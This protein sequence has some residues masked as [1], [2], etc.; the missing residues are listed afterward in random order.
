MN[1]YEAGE[2]MSVGT[3]NS[4]ILTAIKEA[5]GLYWP[6]NLSVTTNYFNNFFAKIFRQTAFV[7]RVAS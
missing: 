6:T 2:V 4:G 1:L 5:Q 7:L 3:K